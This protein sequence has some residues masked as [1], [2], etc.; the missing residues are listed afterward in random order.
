MGK[1]RIFTNV[2]LHIKTIAGWACGILCATPVLAQFN[3]VGSAQSISNNC[4]QLT[5]DVVNQTGAVWFNQQ[6]DLSQDFDI[7]LQ[8]LFGNRNGAG[9]DGIAFVIQRQSTNAGSSGEGLGYQNIT[10]SLIVEFDTFRNTNQGDPDNRHM[11]IMQNGN[12]NHASALTPTVSILPSGLPADDGLYHDVR[13]TWNAT[14]QRL[15]VWVDCQIRLSYS[16]NIVASIF[17]GNP[18]AFWGFTAATGGIV[19]RHQVCNISNSQFNPFSRTITACAGAATTLT[20]S[21]V[22]NNASYLW[23]PNI[24]LSGN[25]ASQVTATAV[26]NQQ[27]ICT[28]TDN[29]YG[30]T[31]RD[32][33]NLQVIPK[34]AT[35][36]PT[37]RPDSLCQGQPLEISVPTL[38]NVV[39]VWTY[40][41][42]AIFAADTLRFAS[43]PVTESGLFRVAANRGGC[44]SDTGSVRV[45]I[46]PFV[47]LAVPYDLQVCLGQ[48]A[49]LSAGQAIP[50]YSFS[51]T[52]P[53]GFTSTQPVPAVPITSFQDTGLYK[54]VVTSG[55]CKDSTTVRV[56]LGTSPVVNFITND[57][58][59]CKPDSF[60]LRLTTNV[61]NLI[62]T[63]DT[64]VA[65]VN[66]NYFFVGNDSVTLVA[67]AANGSFCSTSDTIRIAVNKRPLA[68]AGRDTTILAGNSA[69]L[70]GL[71]DG[72]LPS[73]TWS[74][75]ASLSNPFALN[76]IAM[77]LL[78][79]RYAL[80][81][82]SQPC[83][84]VSDTVQVRVLQRIEI[85]NSF[86]PNGDG[87][88]D[89][90]LIDGLN[91]Y[92]NA[93]VQVF[94]R[95]GSLI[96]ES[97][98]YP[99]P[100]NGTYNGS[101]LPAATYYYV[102][103][104][105]D[106]ND[107]LRGWILLL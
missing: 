23:E 80:T 94:S 49:L 38:P 81:V 43:A 41:S 16:G 106:T 3:F 37:A 2:L 44:V 87:I 73:F 42:G 65:T 1:R 22:M 36:T 14:L 12:P 25:A 47:R 63:P 17:N 55:I 82:T 20:S 4:V 9:A 18:L 83:G 88:N 8:V 39:N 92:A 46:S 107:L 74:N 28:I 89:T 24:N 64:A 95:N 57:T 68:N 45:H 104:V 96:F 10:P 15:Q 60:L 105:P 11:A 19:N 27:Y 33:I 91:S 26:Q 13:F 84:T 53:N 102:I 61:P 48:T 5:N 56:V 29:C 30:G 69:R 77:P 7:R 85:P 66:G 99:T 50:G 35:P 70:Q 98:G 75:T 79:T 6:I 76:P 52:G 97:R 58:T 71:I 100:W 40:P 31:I 21:V 62:F 78:T 67:T 32:T 86:S 34:P 103:K 93:T 54:A 72:T 59:I 51:W 101:K 90:W